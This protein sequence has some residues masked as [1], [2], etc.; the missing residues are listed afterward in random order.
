MLVIHKTSVKSIAFAFD[1][2]KYRLAGVVIAR[3]AQAMRG[4][5]RVSTWLK[6]IDKPPFHNLVQPIRFFVGKL[7]VNLGF[8]ALKVSTCCLE[9]RDAFLIDYKRL[10]EKR[11]FIP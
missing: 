9:Y 10:T 5:L 6:L 11:N 3:L 8:F 7:F 1:N 4:V 2:M